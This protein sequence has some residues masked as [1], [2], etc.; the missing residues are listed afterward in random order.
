MSAFALVDGNSFY[1]SCERVFRPD[2]IGKP[3]VVLSNNDGC[4]VAASAEAKALG[5]KMFGPYFEIADQCREYGVTVFSSNYALYGDMSR[6]MMA[7]LADFAPRQEIYSIDECFL[8]LDGLEDKQERARA[9][10]ENIWRRIGIPACVGIGPSKTLAKLANHLAKKHAEHGG[11]FSWEGRPEPEIDALLAAIPVGKVWGVGPRLAPRLAEEL[12]ITSALEL[13]RADPR[14][15]Q[16]SFG[17]TLERTA[18]ELAGVSCLA[19]ADIAPP[20]QQIISSRSFGEKAARLETLASAV[21]FHVAHAAEKLRA[22]QSVASLIA[23]SIRTSPHQEDPY[24]GYTV[25]PLSPATDDTLALTR[26]AL[27]GLRQIFRP[28]RRYLKAGIVLLEL[29][30]RA[31]RQTDLFSEP[32]DPRRAQLMKTLDAINQAHGRGKIKLAS[33]ALTADWEMRKDQRSPCYTTDIRQLLE[34]R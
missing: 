9:M 24:R 28:G 7:I 11:V 31:L 13:K 2:L 10:R 15:I 32:V 5:L 30:P 34:V 19:L 4:V 23:I 20:R 8:Q 14:L 26:A 17:V 22:Q 33:E 21:S 3:I 27:N 12:E 6:R 29:A 1:A 18:R 25:I 16:R